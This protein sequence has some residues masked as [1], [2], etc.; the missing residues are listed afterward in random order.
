MNVKCLYFI[1]FDSFTA[2]K[3][4]NRLTARAARAILMERKE[5]IMD[6]M[7]LKYFLAVAREENISKAAEY[8]FITQPSLTRQIQ[9][10]EKE[11]GQPLF[12]RGGRKMTL[13]ETG[14]LLRKRAEEIVS[15]FDKTESELMH[16]PAETGGDVFIGGGETYAMKCIAD[17]AR[18]MQADYPNIRFHL[19]SGDIA[20]VC[21]RLDKGLIDFGLVI[22]PA[23]LDKYEHLPLPVKDTWGILL[24]KDHPLAEKDALTREDLKGVPLIHS[25]HALNRSHVSDWFGGAAGLDIV[26]TYNLVYNAALMAEAGMGCVLCLDKLCNASGESPLCFRPL[27]P[28]LESRLNIIWKKYQVFS[29]AA[30]LFLKRLQEKLKPASPEEPQPSDG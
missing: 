7:Q 4:D 27:Y 9:N 24:R 29:G 1:A 22:E 14:L 16:P 26:A 23:N 11:I 3:K 19:F 12:T 8:L 28:P 17:V 30:Q 5:S 13:T 18:S 6:I 15:L 25:R 20:D 10:M 2:Y 21:E